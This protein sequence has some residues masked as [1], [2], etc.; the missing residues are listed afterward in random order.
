MRR[1]SWIPTEVKMAL[2]RSHKGPLEVNMDMETPQIISNSYIEIECSRWPH[3]ILKSEK[4]YHFKQNELLRVRVWQ[5]LIF[6]FILRINQSTQ[7]NT[8]WWFSWQTNYIPK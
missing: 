1:Q 2:F 5:Y 7:N 4:F 8:P 6:Y 3:R